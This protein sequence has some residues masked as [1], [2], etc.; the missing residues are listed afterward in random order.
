M[1]GKLIVFS[2]PSGSG[3][4]SIVKALLKKDVLNVEFSVSAASRLL[5]SKP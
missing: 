4:T 2:G 1:N 3:K 5:F